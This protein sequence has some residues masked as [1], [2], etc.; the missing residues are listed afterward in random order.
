MTAQ[1]FRLDIIA[2]NT[3]NADDYATEPEDAYKRQMVVFNEDRCFKRI[4]W[5]KMGQHVAKRFN[6]VQLR[7]V[8]C[9]QVVEDPTP[10]T[11]VYS[12]DNPL[13]DEFGY[14]YK[15]NVDAATEEMDA[16]EASN[17]Y[18]ANLEVFN[19]VKSMA[20]AALRIGQG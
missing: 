14:V 2:Q 7:G 20:S 15:S 11:P 16:M 17:M 3:V 4:L 9:T 10:P 18:N 8:E 6:Y 1:Q 12:P 5:T 19:L 13:A